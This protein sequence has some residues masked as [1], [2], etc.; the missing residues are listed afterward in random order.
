MSM[1][2]PFVK[3][4][5]CPSQ[6]QLKSLLDESLSGGKLTSVAQH[7]DSCTPC[8]SALDELAEHVLSEEED[9]SSVKTLELGDRN[10]IANLIE[11][12]MKQNVA[13]PESAA[14]AGSHIQLP[15][16]VGPYQLLK[17]VGEGGTGRLYRAL[18]ENLDRIVAVKTLRSE[19][20]AVPSARARFEREARAC[21]A[22][23]HDHI[24][25]VYQVHSGDADEGIPPHLVMEFVEGGSLQERLGQQEGNSADEDLQTKVEWLRQTALALDAAHAQGIVHRDI[26]PSNLLIDKSTGRARVAD[27][28]LARLTEVE[29]Q[30][31]TEGMIAGTPAYMSPEQIVDPAAVDGR[32]DIYSLGVVLY[33]VL[34]GE[35]PFRGIVRMVLHQVL[36]EEPSSP[37]RLNDSL[38]RDLENICLKAMSKERPLR[39]QSAKALADDLQCWLEGLPVSARPVGYFRRVI[40]CCQRNPR[41]AGLGTIV[42]AV[43]IAGAVDWKQY[44]SSR[45]N[46]R[47]EAVQLRANA[48]LQ[49]DVANRQRDMVIRALHTLIIK[50]QN[51]LQSQPGTRELRK[52]ILE[53]AQE[54]LDQLAKGTDSDTAEL[55]TAV[56]QSR[57]GDIYLELGDLDRA[58]SLYSSSRDNLRQCI[59][60]GISPILSRQTLARSLW[61]LGHTDIQQDRHSQ[62]ASQYREA[63]AVI[64]QAQS[65]AEDSQ[66]DLLR[67]S[68]R[69]DSCLAQQR[70]G[71][72]EE[73]LGELV[74]AASHYQSAQQSLEQ[75]LILTPEDVELQRDRAVVILSLASLAADLNRDSASDLFEKSRQAFATLAHNQPGVASAQKDY[76]ACLATIGSWHLTLGHEADAVDLFR[77]ECQIVENLADDS[78]NSPA[79]MREHALCQLRLASLLCR[80]EDWDQADLVIAGA[81]QNLV[82]LMQLGW[83][84]TQDQLF[85]AEAE[86]LSATVVFATGD[87]NAAR[88]QL[89]DLKKRLSQLADK[90]GSAG[91]K[92]LANLNARCEKLLEAMN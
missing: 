55:A 35:L 64:E 43:L 11:Q 6:D 77:H 24:V 59:D 58:M 74:S 49:K 18:D 8:Q 9:T 4:M 38:P 3:P 78:G 14:V 34:T 62:A 2:F 27:F 1:S 80:V 21:A 12:M 87:G 37:R 85:L 44:D 33:Q 79:L 19:L 16:Q 32:S 88:A 89:T 83:E 40:R 15:S 51:K 36:H 25:S 48:L 23:N 29:E 17:M 50:V 63:L 52:S 41:P 75:L 31:T 68:V 86:M 70:L 90:P 91:T 53:A 82:L 65:I 72:V 20:A 73:L 92:Q 67:R 42:L 61:Q 54:E 26:K 84:T 69:R 7:V 22:L 28:G 71:E 46:Q 30:I 47:R 45:E 5:T 81:K 60:K 10:A 57:L 39:Y 76:A 13:E 56:A 66:N